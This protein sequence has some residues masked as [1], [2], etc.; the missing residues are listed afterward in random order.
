MEPWQQGPRMEVP[1]A[2]GPPMHTLPLPFEVP[3]SAA[4]RVRGAKVFDHFDPSNQNEL[5]H[6]PLLSKIGELSDRKNCGTIPINPG[7]PECSLDGEVNL[8]EIVN[9]IDIPHHS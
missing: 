1:S 2:M 4:C 5:Y 6:T 8:L 7:T 9:S 3:C